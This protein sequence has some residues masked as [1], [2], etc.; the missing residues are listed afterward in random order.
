MGAPDDQDIPSLRRR[1][2]EISRWFQIAGAGVSPKDL[3]L[4]YN[5]EQCR[6][7]MMACRACSAKRLVTVDIET[8]GD[9]FRVNRWED[10]ITTVGNG[11]YLDA[12]LEYARDQKRVHFIMRTCRGP[13]VRKRELLERMERRVPILEEVK[14]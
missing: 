14:E 6:A 5:F 10:C 4:H 1:Y 3:V 9:K 8:G 13:D 2:A 11:W 12:D 7:D